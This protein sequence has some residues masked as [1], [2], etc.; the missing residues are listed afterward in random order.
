MNS[1]IKPHYN[2]LKTHCKYG[3]E[4]SSE[5]TDIRKNGGRRCRTCHRSAQNKRKE[6]LRNGRAR[7]ESLKGAGNNMWAG[8][9]V[10]NKALHAWIRRN[11]ASPELCMDCSVKPALDLAN[12]SDKPNPITY[13]RDIKNW[14][15]LCR[16]CHM[17]RDGRIK[18]LKQHVQ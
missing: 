1:T 8:D 6:L 2:S 11:Y 18:N 15:W 17:N 7:Y 10:A 13:T 3:H 14:L 16:S 4:Y 5:N 9:K 12:I